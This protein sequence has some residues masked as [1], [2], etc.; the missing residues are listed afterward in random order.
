ME[1]LIVGV[2][3]FFGAITRFG[4][5]HLEKLL[6]KYTYPFATFFINTLGC[7]L[8]GV[9]FSYLQTSFPENRKLQLF[10]IVGFLGSFTT[11]SA[12]SFDTIQ[13]IETGYVGQALL[14]VVAT[15]ILSFGA[16]WLGRVALSL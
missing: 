13:L 12:F 11:F 4:F 8:A 16:M 9:F 6:P 15:L 14:Y 1:Y 2:G 7:F 3:G 10:I 5:Y